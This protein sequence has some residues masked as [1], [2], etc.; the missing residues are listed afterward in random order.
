MA[1]AL[2]IGRRDAAAGSKANCVGRADDV[3]AY[4]RP[5]LSWPVLLHPPLSCPGLTGASSTPRRFG[6][7]L[8]VSGIP[9]RPIPAPPRLRR[10]LHG[11]RHAEAS[12]KAASR[13][14]TPLLRSECIHQH[15]P[16]IK[17][18][19]LPCGNAAVRWCPG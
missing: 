12:A 9:D 2:G 19:A 7:C 13:A 10:G 16:G 8:T 5:G 14:M 4:P 6:P 3:N 17:T 11:A 15:S 1:R 18:A